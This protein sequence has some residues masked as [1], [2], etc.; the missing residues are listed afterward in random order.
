MTDKDNFSSIYEYVS[1]LPVF[2]D[3]E[4]QRGDEFFREGMSLEKV[5]ANSYIAWTGFV[6]DGTRESR[7]RFL[8]NA[9]FNSYFTWLEKG[10]QKV[11][12]IGSRITLENWDFIS[13][14]IKKTYAADPDFHWRSLLDNGY[15]RQILD[16][17]WDPGLDNG[18]PEVF[19][20]A[21]RID[22]FMYGYNASSVAPNDFIPWERYGFSGGSL[23]DYV[24]HMRNIIIKQYRKGK[25]AAFK[26]AE[27][28][29]RHISFLP[30]D[31][32]A[33]KAA[34]NKPAEEITEEEKILFGNYIFNRCCEL[35]AQLEV[36]FQIHTGLA[37]LSGSRPMNL[38]P[39]IARYPKTRFVL[40][41]SGFPWTNEVS[42]L[43]HNYGNVCPSLTWTATICTS[44][45]VR[46]LHDYIDVSCSINSITWGSDCFVPEDS[47]GA[48]LAWRYIVA[49]VLEE[50]YTDGRMDM[51][52]V[53]ILARKLMYENG[54]RLYLKKI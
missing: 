54:R 31:Y 24:E 50:R 14:T 47:V 11:H 43:A 20:P 38:E 27:A 51:K 23:D 17:F 44:E 28:Y 42:G 45:A 18:H 10:I 53:E 29:N 40:F 12:G 33:A 7:E 5:I 25:V 8:D 15:E 13:D 41:H 30:D 39:V 35:A 1:S 32:E 9:G 48:M 22:K 49:T 3:H 46:A 37:R 26:C 6:S 16:T 21:F 2:S 36:P 4:H 34:F 52:D 19:T